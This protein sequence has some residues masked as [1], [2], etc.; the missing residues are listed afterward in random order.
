LG[1]ISTV[2]LQLDDGP[3]GVFLTVDDEDSL[4]EM[5]ASME[6]VFRRLYAQEGFI[7]YGLKARTVYD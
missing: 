6:L 3:K 4:F 1:G 2:L 5:E 7:R